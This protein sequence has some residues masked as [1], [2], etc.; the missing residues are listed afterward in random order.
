MTLKRLRAEPGNNQPA[1]YRSNRLLH[2]SSSHESWSGSLPCVFSDA[3]QPAPVLRRSAGAACHRPIAS[4]QCCFRALNCRKLACIAEY[5]SWSAWP[6]MN[7]DKAD[8]A[9]M[10]QHDAITDLIAM[11]PTTTAGLQGSSTR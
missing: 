9:C 1:N 8:M 4:H 10:A 7:M 5:P 3:V 2:G 6:G 11:Q